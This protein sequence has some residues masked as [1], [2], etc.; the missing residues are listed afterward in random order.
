MCCSPSTAKPI[1]RRGYYQHPDYGSLF[2]GHLIRGEKS[3]GDSVTLSL[4]REGQ[5]LE[6]KATLTREE[7][8]ARLVPGYNLRQ[9]A[10]LPASRAASSSRNSPAR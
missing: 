9:G 10:Q 5:P 4:L 3:T 8:S 6:L 7:E 2:W 1:D